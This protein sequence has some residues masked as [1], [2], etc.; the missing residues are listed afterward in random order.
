[1]EYDEGLSWYTSH[2]QAFLGVQLGRPTVHIQ[3]IEN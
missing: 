2:K 3:Q 1:M